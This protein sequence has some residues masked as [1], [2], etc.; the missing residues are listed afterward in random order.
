MT[1]NAS[2]M[3]LFKEGKISREEALLFTARHKELETMMAWDRGL[4]GTVARTTPL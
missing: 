4:P 3:K 2:L 1:M